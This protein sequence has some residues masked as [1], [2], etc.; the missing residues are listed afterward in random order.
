MSAEVVVNVVFPRAQGFSPS[1]PAPSSGP[2]LCF[3]SAACWLL[4]RCAYICLLTPLPVPFARL[5]NQDRE[6]KPPLSGHTARQC[7]SSSYVSTE[8]DPQLGTLNSVVTVIKVAQPWFLPSTRLLWVWSF[9]VCLRMS[10][11]G[12][13]HPFEEHRGLRGWENHSE[14]T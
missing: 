12:P 8:S 13:G 9:M 6:V 4:S 3:S 5:G 14:V 7:N 1:I 11:M 2:S 10:L